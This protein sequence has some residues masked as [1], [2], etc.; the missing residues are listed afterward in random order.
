RSSTGSPL[1]FSWLPNLLCLVQLHSPIASQQQFSRLMQNDPHMDTLIDPTHIST[2]RLSLL[3]FMVLLFFCLRKISQHRKPIF[4]LLCH[5]ELLA[6]V[7]EI[8]IMSC[9]G[10]LWCE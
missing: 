10:I 1:A 6:V 5:A 3:D 8:N 4:Q 9:S 2:C 7:I